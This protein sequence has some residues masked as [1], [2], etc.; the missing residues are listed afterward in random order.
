MGFWGISESI[1]SILGG[2]AG[3]AALVWSAVAAV[4]AR[5]RRLAEAE[6]TRRQA[7]RLVTA[8]IVSEPN[9]HWD[10]DHLPRP[11][12]A[13]IAPREYDQVII[14]VD[15]LSAGTGVAHAFRDD[16]AWPVEA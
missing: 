10:N 2:A 9:V 16:R 14:Q 6:E 12:N 8:D 4:R 13:Q 11:V 15:G 3:I 7:A 5:D 1:G